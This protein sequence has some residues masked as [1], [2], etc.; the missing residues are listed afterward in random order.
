MLPSALPETPGYP[1]SGWAS[2]RSDERE[3]REER[4][5]AEQTVV[6]RRSDGRPRRFSELSAGRLTI[7][8][9]R[10]TRELLEHEVE[11]G[12]GREAGVHG[13]RQHL[14]ALR[15]TGRDAALNLA[16]PVAVHEVVERLA[17]L[18]VEHLGQLVR[19]RVQAR[20]EVC[21]RQ[22]A[23]L[24]GTIPIHHLEQRLL[25]ALGLAFGEA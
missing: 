21:E 24:P 6:R 1:R 9:R 16:D 12:L 13:Q 4:A 15:L 20:R 23:V 22:V 17:Q 18:R 10:L 2:Q 14:H 5:R 19:R 8:R 3:Q 25:E 7:V 11:R